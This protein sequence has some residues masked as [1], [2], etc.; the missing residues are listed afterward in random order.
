MTTLEHFSEALAYDAT[1][2]A[3][4]WR[5]GP[6]AGQPAGSIE[7]G[8]YVILGYARKRCKA[9]RLALLMSGISLLDEQVVDHING[10]PSDNRLANL[11]VTDRAGNRRNQQKVRSDSK[12]GFLGVRR[13]KKAFRGVISVNGKKVCLPMRETPEMAHADYLSAKRKFHPEFSG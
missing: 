1:S 6:R 11:R 10:N 4:T 8:G 2:G 3:F 5:S 12:T 9:H 13:H 7:L